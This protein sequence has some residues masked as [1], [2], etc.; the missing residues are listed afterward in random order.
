MRNTN[1]HDG[2]IGVPHR[3]RTAF[4]MAF[5]LAWALSA[6]AHRESPSP[7]PLAVG[8]AVVS[9]LD[10]QPI[11]D[12]RLDEDLHAL[13]KRKF[14]H[15]FDF[16]NPPVRASK[17]SYRLGYTATHLYVYIETDAAEV[18]HQP[19]G[20]LRGDGYRLLVGRPEADGLASE[21]FDL[22]F[23]PTRDPKREWDRQRIASYNHQTPRSQLSAM[24]HSAEHAGDGRSGFEALIAWEDLWPYHPWDGAP[25]GFNLYFA[26][27]HP[28]LA[29]EPITHGYAVRAD[30]GIWDEEIARRAVKLLSFERPRE[31]ASPFLLLRPEKVSLAAQQ[32]SRIRTRLFRMGSDVDTTLVASLFDHE[33]LERWT[34]EWQQRPGLDGPVQKQLLDLPPL[35]EGKYSLQVSGA[36]TH[37]SA[38]IC[39]LPDVDY[40][41]LRDELKMPVGPRRG[42]AEALSF[43]LAQ[44]EKASVLKP[45][46]SCEGVLEGWRSLKP[47]LSAWQ[48]GKDPYA[49]VRG[50]YRRGFR[51]VHDD[52][53]Q[54]MTIKLPADYSSNR[55]YP[56]LVMLH[57]SAQDDT[58]ILDHDWSGGQAIEL[59]PFGRDR[60]QAYAR[61]ESQLD[62]VEA[63]E[64]AQRDFSV[65]SA[66]VVIAGFSMG[67][68]G[69]LRTFCEQPGRYVGVAMLAGHPNLASEW[70]GEP[71]PDFRQV[72]AASAFRDVPVF[73]YHGDADEA[74]DPALA[75]AAAESLT[76]AG[77]HVHLLMPEG[78]THRYPA[79]PSL[80]QFQNWLR[81]TWNTPKRSGNPG[82]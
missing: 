12:G 42:V 7:D 28:A 10:W 35:P 2:A 72:R 18:T 43:E 68:Y 11:V 75:E 47:M 17:L 55:K 39:V 51:S 74:L 81:E 67:G 82:G 70:L 19:R 44:L 15:F 25:I 1:P 58:Q 37:A 71:H 30:E 64:T 48:Q 38:P 62:I 61:P 8:D 60:F 73:I 5:A 79:G 59:A 52:T 34:R 49:G 63:I 14:V 32:S 33:G 78:A 27:A 50:P 20:Y 4:V 23:S 66:R 22:T 80:A 24:S 29:G 9:F 65:D 13:P 40:A 56:L 31:M 69:A 54:P 21:Y 36:G 6:C 53:L 57:G 76:A 77:A 16:D 41:A 45:Y 46:E 3:S 26:K